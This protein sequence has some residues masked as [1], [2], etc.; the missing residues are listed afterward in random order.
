MKITSYAA[1]KHAL[2]GY[3]NSLR[4]ELKYKKSS[5]RTTLVCPW[6]INTGMVN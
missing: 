3:H 6:G 2:W 1:S 5:I 4:M